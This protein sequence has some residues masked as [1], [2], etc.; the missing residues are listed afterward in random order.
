MLILPIFLPSAGKRTEDVGLFFL[1]EIKAKRLTA[2]LNLKY[3][4][5]LCRMKHHLWDWIGRKQ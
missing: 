1:L 2:R 5:L 4:P 3:A